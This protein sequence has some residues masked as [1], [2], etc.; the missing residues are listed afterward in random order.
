MQSTSSSV[1]DEIRHAKPAA[2]KKRTFQPS[3]N[4]K[5]AEIIRAQEGKQ[6]M[7]VECPINF[8]FYGGAA[9][10]G[11]SYGI[12]LRALRH[13]KMIDD[14]KKRKDFTGSQESYAN[15]LILRREMG[16]LKD[17]VKKFKSVFLRLG[18][19]FKE[20]E[21]EFDFYGH[22]ITLGYVKDS[23]SFNKFQGQE[24]TF[25]AVDEITQFNADENENIELV[26]SRLRNENS[27]FPKEKI[28]TGNPGG[29]GHNF[30]KGRYIDQGTPNLPFKIFQGKRVFEG[31]DDWNEAEWFVYIPSKLSDNKFL[32]A[33]GQYEKALKRL[34]LPKELIRAYLEG[35]WNI[36]LG[37]MFDDLFTPSKHIVKKSLL[38]VPSNYKLKRGFDWGSS[39]PFAAIWMFEADGYSQIKYNGKLIK[40]P[41]GSIIVFDEFYGCE[42]GKV[43]TGVKYKAS[44]I[45][46]MM[47]EREKR[48]GI[49]VHAG[50]ADS[51]IWNIESNGLSIY[52]EFSKSKIT[53]EKSAKGNG[54]RAQGWLKLREMFQAVLEESETEPWILFC[55][56]CVNTIRTIPMLPRDVK[57]NDDVDS[58][59]EDHIA[60]VIRYNIGKSQNTVYKVS[61][62]AEM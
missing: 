44:K 5:V 1:A 39:K 55:D 8:I 16:G 53:F 61:A 52:D 25:V 7:F 49:K 31:D 34:A 15:M 38:Q 59:S 13:I 4:K 58:K 20:G 27:E 46:E 41:K 17:L 51:A 54:S 28:M 26:F 35:D 60:D 43:D 19:T 36:V 30:I 22:K 57:D 10:G 32:F 2:N 6:R 12:V 9:G 18:A 14:I 33:D 47:I 42:Q 24:Y 62:S 56:T 45:A 23:K 29:K 40:L 11:K 37:G 21:K 48:F 50:V 3:K